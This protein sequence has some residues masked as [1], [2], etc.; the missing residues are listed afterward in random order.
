MQTDPK[1]RPYQWLAE[2]YDRLFAGTRGPMDAARERLLG[3]ILPRVSSACDL[4]CGTGNAAISLAR[5]GIR[6]FA[7]DLS[8]VMCR[9]AR[10]KARR[11]GLPLRVIRADMRDFRL[12]EP[13]DLVLCEFDALNHVPHKEDLARVAQSVAKALKPGG[14]F[15]FDVN[16]RAGFAG[17]WTGS[18]WIEEP[19]VVLVMRNGN[20]ARHDRAWSDVE[21]FIREGNLWR[22]RRER[23]DE[24]CWSAAEMRK[25][26]RDAGFDR[27]RAWDSAPFWPGN[28]MIRPGCRTNY[29]ARKAAA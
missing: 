10:E 3:K 6:T 25:A 24:V 17:Y 14:H 13:V 16:N 22:R 29:L 9:L 18:V 28:P 12:P 19:G 26:L 21:W 8:P 2:Y 1:R 27:I 20:D 15:Y 23:V 7:V 5:R 11:E 4:A